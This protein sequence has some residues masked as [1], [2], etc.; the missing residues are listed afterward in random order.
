MAEPRP[1]WP[2][3]GRGAAPGAFTTRRLERIAEDALRAADVVG[4]LPT[5]LEA[6]HPVA[7]IRALEP[8]P[9]L[10]DGIRTPG[11]RL[12]GALWFEER[13]IFLEQQQSAARRRFTEAH[14]L[15]HALCPWHAAVLREDTGDEL[16]KA[17][18]DRIEVEA[19]LGAGMLLFQGRRFAE[20]VGAEPPSLSTPL[21][22]AR[23]Y[24]AS[25]HAAAHHYVLTHAAAVA[26][27][28][29]GRFPQRDG[30]LP[31]W[32]SVESRRY[33]ERCKGVAAT[34]PP[35]LAAGTPLRELVEAAR[36]AS[37]PAVAALRWRHRDGAVRR[38]VA[39]AH[40]NRHAFLV[41][42]APAAY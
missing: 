16:F 8:L 18:R 17:T 20:R 13:T 36:R 29:V 28:V 24:G 5:P 27:L 1:A 39:H 4:V 25:A 15:M 32:R 33:R 34:I 38:M 21:A 22:L 31:V 6:L 35:G 2:G 40:Y 19:N 37:E 9:A 10:P 14:E 41:L 7:G 42:L 3:S 26:M 30:S 12:L 23:E 11:R